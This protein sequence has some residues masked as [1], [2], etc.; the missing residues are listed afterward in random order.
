M[1]IV[2]CVKHVP[3][4]QAD[5]TFTAGLHDR[6]GRCRR[7]AQ[8]A[9]R[10]RRRGGAEAAGGRRRRRGRRADDGAGRRRGRRPQVAA[11]GRGLRGARLRRRHRRLRRPR[12]VPRAGSR[13]EKIGDVDLVLTGMAST[14]GSDGRRPG[15]ARRAARPA[16][17]HVRLRAHARRRHRD[18]PP[19]RRRLD[20]DRQAA[21]P[22]V[23]SVTDQI[24]EPRY[25]S[26][27]GI[28]A[29]KK[30]PRGDLGAGRPR[31]RRRRRRARRRVDAV[32][33]APR[34]RRATPAQVVTDEGD[35]GARL[36]EFLAE[37]K[38]V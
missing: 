27:K 24:N 9:R 31:R 30:K 37:H 10:V 5:R 13:V 35:G 32:E 34:A 26:F 20:R 22:A 18:D 36:A 4:A 17:G 25:P 7:A 14:D 19:R 38:F 2:V 8:R 11:D 15:D 28:M 29:A 21:L 23:V 6:P 12:D 1:K 33:A 3:D 16:A